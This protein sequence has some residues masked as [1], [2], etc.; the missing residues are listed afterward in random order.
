MKK[1]ILCLMS[2][3]LFTGVAFAQKGLNCYPVFQG[4]VIP[5]RQMIVTEVR[6]NS[7]ATYKISYY[8]SVRLQVDTLTARRVAALVEAD[9]LT[10]DSAET[11]KTGELLTYG[12]IQLKPMGIT[13]RYLC[14]QARPTEFHGW[15]ITMIYLEGS[16]TLKDLRSMFEKQ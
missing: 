9:A 16:A 7:M 10:A 13:R 1:I 12:L 14:Y 8:R 6:G 5:E 15:M 4:K 11:E 3:L 2:L